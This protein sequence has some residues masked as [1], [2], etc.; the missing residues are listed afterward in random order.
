MIL[1]ASMVKKAVSL[2]AIAN[3]IHDLLEPLD[4]AVRLRAVNAAL[5]L[6]GDASI[7]PGGK[8]KQKEDV[9]EEEGGGDVGEL[10]QKGKAW[11]RK[12]NVKG[13][14][15][16]E[17]FDLDGETVEVIADDVPGSTAKE[18]TINAYV[19][20]GIGQ[21]LKTGDVK[22]GDDDARAVCKHIGCL[23]PTNHSHYMSGRKNYF[24]G[25]KK[26]GWKLTAPGLKKGAELVGAIANG[27]E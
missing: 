13:D 23:N 22:F 24:G 20:T 26:T 2:P 16:G 11:M 9:H 12:Y 3:A 15:L 17:V 18:K 8:A 4:T 5:T 10:S 14:D 27:G 6:L 7:S 19:I 1:G 25:A 21:Y